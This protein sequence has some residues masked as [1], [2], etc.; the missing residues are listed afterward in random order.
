M[1]NTIRDGSNRSFKSHLSRLL[2][3]RYTSPGNAESY[4]P[5][6]WYHLKSLYDTL[7]LRVMLDQLLSVTKQFQAPGSASRESNLPQIFM[8]TSPDHRELDWPRPTGP[9]LV[10]IDRLREM[11]AVLLC[12]A[13]IHSLTR[14]A[15]KTR[16]FLSWITG[17]SACS[18]AF[19]LVYLLAVD[20]SIRTGTECFQRTSERTP[21]GCSN[22]QY[23]SPFNSTQP[24]DSHDRG[25]E[26]LMK[27]TLSILDTVGKQFSRLS[28]YKT[29]IQ[30]LHHRA[31]ATHQTGSDGFHDPS[32]D[33]GPTVPRSMRNIVK[34][35]VDQFDTHARNASES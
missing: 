24:D 8:S 29:V 14:S 15:M 3:W 34:A 35:I 1:S 21:R 20:P 9:N 17:Y 7:L 16:H 23:S 22:V 11:K 12:Q 2:H 5:E 18:A 33:M 28:E 13:V 25:F 31:S 19:A 26:D 6:Q 10:L 30:A 32:L 4:P 27:E